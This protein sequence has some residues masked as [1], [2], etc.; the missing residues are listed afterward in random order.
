MRFFQS[1]VTPLGTII[2]Y[3]PIF[4]LFT[5]NEISKFYLNQTL[6]GR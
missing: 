6:L 4:Q 3:Y 1:R 5:S 2:L